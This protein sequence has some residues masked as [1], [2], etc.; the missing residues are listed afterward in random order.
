VNDV[1]ETNRT[2]ALPVRWGLVGAILALSTVVS[3]ACLYQQQVTSA[4]GALPPDDGSLGAT[5][6]RLAAVEDFLG[7]YPVWLGARDALSEKTE[8]ATRAQKLRTAR[9]IADSNDKANEMMRGDAA[10][11]ARLRGVALAEQGNFAGALAEFRTALDVAPPGWTGR[12][13]V[14]RDAAAFE[15]WLENNE[16]EGR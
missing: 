16:T 7:R 3:F 12:A 14:E 2:A 15:D 9:A 13:Q 8:L 5:E 6:T 1:R 10:D 11:S 4:W